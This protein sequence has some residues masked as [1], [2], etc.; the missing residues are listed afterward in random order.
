MRNAFNIFADLEAGSGAG[1]LKPVIYV[2]E[3]VKS[4]ILHVEIRY[5][6][7]VF[8]HLCCYACFAGL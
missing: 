5:Y 4:H 2:V 8:N 3:N 1:Q 6:A 7:E